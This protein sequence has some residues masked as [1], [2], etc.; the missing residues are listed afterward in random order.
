MSNPSA[1]RCA[2]LGASFSLLL[3]AP[4][5]HARDEPPPKAVAEVQ[6][7]KAA[8]RNVS[9][10]PQ[11]AAP[12]VVGRATFDVDPIADTGIIVLASGFAFVLELINSTGEIRPQQIASGFDRN[13]LIGIDKASLTSTPSAQAGT[14]SN[15]G[16]GAPVA[17][18]M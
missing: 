7:P 1:A 17:F 14:L 16:L 11:L 15:L 4:W 6:P 3:L 12:P 13:N 5:A 8:E 18:A 10:E 2:A 9:L